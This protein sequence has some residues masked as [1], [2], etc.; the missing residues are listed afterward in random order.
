MNILLPLLS[1]LNIYKLKRAF[2]S[3]I[4]IYRACEFADRRENGRG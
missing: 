4:D 2:G 1:R 3:P